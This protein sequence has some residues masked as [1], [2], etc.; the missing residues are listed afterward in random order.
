VKGLVKV[1]EYVA[2]LRKNWPCTVEGAEATVIATAVTTRSEALMDII[3]ALNG[4]NFRDA[5]TFVLELAVTEHNESIE[6]S[7]LPDLQELKL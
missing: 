2:L 3:D 7:G 5:A 4:A 1:N 6:A